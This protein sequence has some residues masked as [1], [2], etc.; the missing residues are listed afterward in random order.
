M[1]EE[2][3]IVFIDLVDQWVTKKININIYKYI[4]L[5]LY[6]YEHKN[7]SYYGYNFQINL[8]KNLWSKFGII[9]GE[10]DYKFYFFV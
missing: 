3:H 2:S 5:Y 6:I 7:V 1:E 8:N 4:Y 9:N 10:I